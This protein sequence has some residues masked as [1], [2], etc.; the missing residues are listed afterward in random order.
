MLWKTRLTDS[1]DNGKNADDIAGTFKEI[2]AS[3]ETVAMMYVNPK[4]MLSL[5]GFGVTKAHAVGGIL[6]SQYM[7]HPISEDGAI[8]DNVVMTVSYATGHFG[9]LR[10]E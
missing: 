8:P 9:K 10:D 4:T 7:G 1:N 6:Y 5:L 3:S 2:D